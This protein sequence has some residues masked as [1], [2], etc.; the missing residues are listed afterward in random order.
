VPPRAL[1][2][3]FQ[4][5]VSGVIMADKKDADKNFFIKRD[6]LRDISFVGKLLGEATEERHTARVYRAQNGKFIA[7]LEHFDHAHV[8]DSYSGIVAETPEEIA[9]FFTSKKV[10]GGGKDRVSSEHLNA[11]GKTAMRL[12]A[13]GD[14]R[15]LSHS[16]EVV[17]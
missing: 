9:A 6:G 14:T 7:S 8:S 1:R 11:A 17:E 2:F 3:D 5:P 16:V 13:S 12:A 15:F 10:E 4:I